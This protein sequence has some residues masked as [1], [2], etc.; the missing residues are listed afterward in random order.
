MDFTDLAAAEVTL[1]EVGGGG[2]TYVRKVRP[3]GEGLVV[4]GIAFGTYRASVTLA[5]RPLRLALWGEETYGPSVTH[6]FTMGWL[7]DQFRVMAQP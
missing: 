2:R 3:S 4:T 1:V 7:G 5:G 6:D